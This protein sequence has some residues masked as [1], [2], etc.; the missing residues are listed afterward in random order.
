VD[1]EKDGEDGRDVMEKERGLVVD[2]GTIQPLKRRPK[3]MASK[4]LSTQSMLTL[5]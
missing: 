1:G 5:S 2:G 4:I 3:P